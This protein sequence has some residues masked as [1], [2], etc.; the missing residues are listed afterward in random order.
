MD[1]S[2]RFLE[3]REVEELVELEAEELELEVSVHSRIVNMKHVRVIKHRHGQS[4]VLFQYD[5]LVEFQ[6]H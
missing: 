6:R 2:V 3:L 1:L 5:V 4:Q